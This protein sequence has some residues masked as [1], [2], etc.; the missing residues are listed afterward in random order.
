MSGEE[1]D[2]SFESIYNSTCSYD[3]NN[4]EECLIKEKKTGFCYNCYLYFLLYCC[5]LGNNMS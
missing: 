3:N 1:S 4:I 5:C 2:M